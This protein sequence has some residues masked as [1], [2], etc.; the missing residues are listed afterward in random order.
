MTNKTTKK[1]GSFIKDIADTLEKYYKQALSER[2]K[3]GWG[4]E[5][6]EKVIHTLREFWAMC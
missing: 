1:E 5:K 2:I 4:R 6:R 3:R